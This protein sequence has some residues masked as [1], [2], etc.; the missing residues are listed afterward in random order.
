MGSTPKIGSIGLK[1]KL[2]RLVVLKCIFANFG[3]DSSSA[4]IWKVFTDGQTDMARSS[5]LSMLFM[6]IHTYF[7]GSISI[8]SLCYAQP[9]KRNIPWQAGPAGYKK[10]S[11]VLKG[12]PKRTSFLKK[13]SKKHLNLKKSKKESKIKHL[14]FEKAPKKHFILQKST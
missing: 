5:S 2:D 9:H 8:P 12:H 1:F 4:S 3:S 6:P 13:R 14:C 7:V 11:K 10:T